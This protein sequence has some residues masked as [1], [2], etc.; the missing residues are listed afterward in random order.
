[1]R[2]HKRVLKVKTLLVGTRMD[3]MHPVLLAE[4]E[5]GYRGNLKLGTVFDF[6]S[7]LVIQR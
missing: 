6:S 4:I 1:M 5:F 3:V 7:F 2:H